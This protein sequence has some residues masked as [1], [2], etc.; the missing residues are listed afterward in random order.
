[1]GKR[2]LGCRADNL[3]VAP[4]RT[5][6]IVVAA[7]F[8]RG[9]APFEHLLSN[10]KVDGASSRVDA[11][12]VPILDEGDRTAEGGL[13]TDMTDTKAARGTREAAIGDQR[14]LFTHTASVD[15][16]G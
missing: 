4:Q 6:L 3:R 8:P 11:D 2:A 15:C 7:W 16:R 5:R 13:G 9:P 12:D 1:M 14:D 10:F